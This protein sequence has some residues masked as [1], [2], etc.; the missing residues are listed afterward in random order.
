MLIATPTLSGI[1]D[2]VAKQ[3]LELKAG[4]TNCFG[5]TEFYTRVHTGVPANGDYDIENALIDGARAVDTNTIS[6]ALFRTTYSTLVQS[7]ESHGTTF[8]AQSFDSWLNVS[9]LNVHPDFEDVWYRVKNVHLDAVN[10]FFSDANILVASFTSTGSGTG[11]YTSSNPVGTGTGK[12]SATNH[13]AANMV[14]VPVQ[15]VGGD[16]Q[17]NLRLTEENLAGGTR[18]NKFDNILVPSGT[19][20]GTQFPVNNR[21]SGG[22]MYLDVH[23]IVAAGGDGNDVFRVYALREREI[24]L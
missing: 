19:L 23:N 5:G 22:H 14:L 3:A 7:I 20:S 11:T 24:R 18:T 15:D 17:I 8:N 12:V 4:I 21:I 9:G 10:V 1:L 13:A 2:R 6:G 16:I